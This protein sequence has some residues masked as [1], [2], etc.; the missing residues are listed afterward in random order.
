MSPPLFCLLAYTISSAHKGVI[1][2]IHSSFS[3]SNAIA[4][5]PHP[6]TLF[7]FALSRVAAALL[8][9]FLHDLIC[10][11]RFALARVAAALLL[12]CLHDLICSQSLKAYRL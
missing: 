7:G 9:A 4:H 6:S 1:P 2:E 12:A 11:Q 8:L 10:S 5:C 3:L